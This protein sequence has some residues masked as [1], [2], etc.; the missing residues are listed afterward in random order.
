MQAFR[1]HGGKVLMWHGWTDTTL[2]PRQSIAYYNRIIAAAQ[3]KT[4]V[5]DGQA[6][7]DTQSYIRLFMAPGVNHCGGGP[8]PGST[9][10]YTLANAAGP[11]DADHDALAALERWVESGAAPDMFVSSHVTDG[12]VDRSRPLCAYPKVAQYRG[13]GDV[14]Q[15]GSFVCADDWNNFR[16]DFSKAVR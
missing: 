11:A 12:R 3:A 4:D 6:L 15:A 10:A 7:A 5:P 13:T 9:F 1:S 16:R 14:N 8:G 2:E